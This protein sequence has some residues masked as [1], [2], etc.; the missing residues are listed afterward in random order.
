VHRAARSLPV[1]D[2]AFELL[3]GRAPERPFF[4]FAHYFD[5]H[6]EYL[7]H[8]GWKLADGY[9]GW[10]RGQL[11]FENLQ[12]NGRLLKD[13]DRRWLFDLYQEELLYTD[14]HVGRLLAFLAESGLDES[15]LI[16]VVADHGE[17]FGEHDAYYGHTITMQQEVLH[18]PLL[19]V[20]PAGSGVAPRTVDEVVETRSV[21]GT[22]LAELG[23]A[24]V[25]GAPEG[26]WTPGQA[27]RQSL[28][29]E[30][31]GMGHAFSGVFLDTT[32]PRHGKRFKQ[33]ALVRGRHKVAYDMTR[34]VFE[35]FDLAADP[36]ET[37]PLG[38]GRNQ[39]VAVPM[40]EA[41]REWVERMQRIAQ[42]VRRVQL[43]GTDLDAMHKLGYVDGT[44]TEAQPETTEEETRP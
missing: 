25:E 26:A 34:G 19:V 29:G 11:D 35:L 36:G 10:F 37:T 38:I 27:R 18:V 42:E 15:T 23:V 8:A 13:E 21:F 17:A 33:A 5:P 2:G 1:T 41:L 20:P 28:L 24:P 16:V 9:E 44:A 14:R 7:D 43:T 22:V 4:L 30:A 31:A 40:R 3:Q 32:D 12:K 6:Y 39:E